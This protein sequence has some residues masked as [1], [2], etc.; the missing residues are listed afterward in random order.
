MGD[1]GKEGGG[2]G[3]EGEEEVLLFVGC[4]VGYEDGERPVASPA[5]GSS[6]I[7][8]ETPARPDMLKEGR[9]SVS[10]CSLSFGL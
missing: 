2:G 10:V 8:R 3:G 6:S 4:V 1:L 5:S 9:V 7:S